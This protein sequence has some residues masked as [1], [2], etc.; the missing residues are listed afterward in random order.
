VVQATGLSMNPVAGGYV[1]DVNGFARTTNTI[2]LGSTVMPSVTSGTTYGSTALVG[3]FGSGSSSYWG[4]LACNVIYTNNTGGW[5]QYTA[6]LQRMV[7]SSSFSY[8]D[9]MPYVGNGFDY[10]GLAFGTGNTS[11]G[12]EFMR[13]KGNG[14]V[15]IG[16]TNP[17]YALDI[18]GSLN[19]TG[20]ILSNGSAIP[21]STGS[22]WSTSGSMISY[23]GGNVG[24]GTTNPTTKFTVYSTAYNTHQLLLTGQEFYG[25]GFA[26]TGISLNA[27]VNR[28]NNK[29]LWIMDPDLALNTTNTTI[30]ITPGPGVGFIGSVSTDGTT[31]MPLYFSGSPSV[32]QSGNVGIGKTN[33]STKLWVVS[34][35]TSSTFGGTAQ[36][37]GIHLQPSGTND[38]ITGIT[39]GGNGGYESQTQAGIISQAS[40]GYGS[41]LFFQTTNDYS[42]GAKTRMMIDHA[43]YI[44]IGITTPTFP[45]HLYNTSPGILFQSSSYLSNPFYL[46]IGTSNGAL[47]IGPNVNS[48]TPGCNLPIGGNAWQ[49]TSDARL[50]KDVVTM[51]SSLDRLNRLRPV[52]FRY[53]NDKDTDDTR[54]GFIAQEV[55]SVIPSQW[56]VNDNGMPEIQYDEEGH[57]YKALSMCD[58]QLTPYMVKS[59]QELSAKNKDLEA[60]VIRLADTVQTLTAQV[61]QLLSASR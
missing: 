11:T 2:T 26:S 12:T 52:L 31:V 58:S 47:Y 43:G 25:N 34:D 37:A 38:S 22:V 15:G 50:K 39:F 3:Q 51:E 4:S 49:V 45:V 59:I 24:V 60:Q 1:L 7:D 32:F 6:R 5:T 61:S 19:V 44:G 8:I 17:A 48:A 35:V 57:P 53:K 14:Y 13:I 10:N 29:Q 40:T 46:F 30:R 36:W 20:S 27:G 42:A 16:K 18:S 21:V 23:T 28:N 33:P 9:F 55:Q 54:A 56:L 41:K